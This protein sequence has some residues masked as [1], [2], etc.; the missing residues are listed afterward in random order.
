MKK[1]PDFMIKGPVLYSSYDAPIGRLYT[2]AT[3]EGIIEVSIGRGEGEFLERLGKRYGGEVDLRMHQKPFGLLF[4]E[5][6]VYFRG[7]PMEF[8]VPL[9]FYGAPFDLAVWEALMRIPR[10]E[11][12]SYASVASMIGRPRGARAVGGAC[13]RNRLPI[14]VPCHRVLSAGGGLGG[15]T[16]G[17]DVK[18][19]LLEIEGISL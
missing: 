16:G 14:I 1:L 9:K 17:L 4:R 3:V 7:A 11:T 2:A 12:R 19:A 15:Y 6:D 13:G 18:R 8:T 5:F 10:G